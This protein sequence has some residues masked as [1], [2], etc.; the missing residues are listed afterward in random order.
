MNDTAINWI[1]GVWTALYSTV[2]ESFVA[3]YLSVAITAAV[4]FFSISLVPFQQYAASYTPV[5]FRYIRKDRALI[6]AFSGLIAVVVGM[7]I[8]PFFP[9]TFLRELIAVIGLLLVL[10]LIGTLWQITTRL[11]NPLDFLLPALEKSINSSILESFDSVEAKQQTDVEKLQIL[12]DMMQQAILTAEQ[13]EPSTETY[14]IS[15]ADIA[16]AFEQIITLKE[17][18]A[19]SL[20]EGQSHVFKAC[21]ESLQRC[22][23]V[24]WERR[25]DY[26]SAFDNLAMD[27]ADEIKDIIS[28]ADSSSNIHGHRAIWRFIANTSIDSLRITAIGGQSADHTIAKPLQS[29]I[30]SHVYED[31]AAKRID[32]AYES[33]RAL[34]Q[35]GTAHA[36]SNYISS[37]AYLAKA[38]AERALFAELHGQSVVSSIGKT[39][40][41][42]IFFRMIANR[43]SF[44]NYDQPYTHVV[45]C[46]DAIMEK[47]NPPIGIG[48]NDPIFWWNAD[49]FQDRSISSLVRVCLW[50]NGTGDED[51]YDRLVAANLD[52]ASEL[53]ELMQKHFDKDG[54]TQSSYSGQL[55]QSGLWLLAFVYHEISMDLLLVAGEIQIPKYSN[56]DRAN[57][58]LDEIMNWMT[59]RILRDWKDR[60]DHLMHRS[61]MLHGLLS[62]AYL[63]V[64]FAAT[65]GRGER[66]ALQCLKDIVTGAIGDRGAID[67]SGEELD[68]LYKFGKYLTGLQP[69]RRIGRRLTFLNRAAIRTRRP[70]GWG[71]MREIAFIKRPIVTF[72]ARHFEAW[73]AAIFGRN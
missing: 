30:E 31:L 1:T 15:R 52:V 33:I 35:I 71:R 12:D 47:G 17:F 60:A 11:L 59:D 37:A 46:Y 22:V 26:G 41:A 34:G 61:E 49:F 72:D 32:S 16:G 8:I 42:E 70:R 27:L 62:L 43:R 66:E 53:L 18:A 29:L 73:D 5:L 2:D 9:S 69:Y 39:Y 24:Y 19:R 55:Y 10:G 38:I 57:R 40:L 44:T 50:P 20:R 6:S 68:A 13:V 28:V 14:R 45:E 25:K 21:L 65:Y 48:G 54:T 7:A 67:A 56:A 51:E 3:T 63:R 4:V 58:L 64:H 23:S 36:N